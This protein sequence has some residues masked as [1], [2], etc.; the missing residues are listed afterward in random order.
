MNLDDYKELYQKSQEQISE[1]ISL[2]KKSNNQINELIKIVLKSDPLLKNDPELY[3]KRRI[4]YIRNSTAYE[5]L[6]K[7]PAIIINVIPED[8]QSEIFNSFSEIDNQ[9]VLPLIAPINFSYELMFNCDGLMAFHNFDIIRHYNLANRNNSFESFNSLNTSFGAPQ[10]A[11][12]KY[13]DTVA[14]TIFNG[15]KLLN[16]LSG[17]NEFSIFITLSNIKGVSVA[18]SDTITE[19]F[20]LD[21]VYLP[22][23][24]ANKD[25][26]LEEIRTLIKYPTSVM[27]QI[28]NYNI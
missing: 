16:N 17:N 14:K 1:L 7:D 9:I 24:K 19:P 5:K 13:Y 15:I 25:N 11:I 20:N 27:L 28:C 12:Y 8:F 6:T 18:T 23:I 4:D 3:V 21:N 10:I 2:L 22:F 26:T